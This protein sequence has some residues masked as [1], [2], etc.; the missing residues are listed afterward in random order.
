MIIGLSSGNGLTE[1]NIDDVSFVV[2]PALIVGNPDDDV[3]V[4]VRPAL[5]GGNPDVT[6]ALIGGNPVDVE[7]WKLCC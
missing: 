7:D 3:S 5:I 2:T 6:P 4:D 1:G